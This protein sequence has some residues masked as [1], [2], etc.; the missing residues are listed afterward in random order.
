MKKTLILSA[1]TLAAFC[2]LSCQKENNE[3]VPEVNAEIETNKE[4]EHNPYFVPTKT[5]TFV[6]TV[7]D[8]VNADTKTSL[9]GTHIKWAANEGIYLFDGYAPRAFT[10]DNADVASTVNFE[11]SAAGTG[12]YWAVY[13]AGKISTVESKKVI[14]ATIPTIQAATANSF[15]AKANV[16]VAYTA[17]DPTGDGVLLFKNVGA[18]LKLKLNADNDN[19]SKI[20]IDA[21]GG[22][23]MT[24]AVDVTFESDGSF[25]SAIVNAKSESFV[26]LDNDG[27]ALD[28]SKTY[29]AAINKGTYTGGFRITLYN[30]DGT[31]FRAVKNTTTAV[32]DRNDLMDLGTLPKIGNSDWKAPVVDELTATLTGRTS[33]GDWSGKTS[34]SDAVYAGNS[35]KGD[36]AH[37]YALQIRSS[38]NS[39]IVTTASG[40]KAKRIVVDWQSGTA[41]NR[42][43]DV[44]GKNSAYTASSNLYSAES[45]TLGTKIGSIVYGTSTSLDIK[46]DYEY[47]GLRSNDGAMWF[48]NIKIYWGD[49]APEDPS[50]PVQTT[51]ITD[52][53]SSSVPLTS[54]S[55]TFTVSSNGPWTIASNQ[56]YATVTVSDSDVATVT[57]ENLASGSRSATITVTPAEGSQ[58]SVTITQQATSTYHYEALTAAPSDWTAFTYIIVANGKVLNGSVDGDWGL[59]NSPTIES[60]GTIKQ[61]SA[62]EACEVTVAGDNTNGYTLY[63][64]NLSTAAYVQPQTSKTFATTTST[65]GKV[66]LAI[67]SISNHSSTGWKL[68][69]NNDKFRWYNS[70]TGTAAVLY[71]KVLDSAE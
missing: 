23:K 69:L 65:P 6:G 7:D 5:V 49:V 51:S 38:S 26:I 45:S 14:R 13:P 70:N 10:S 15:A 61:T 29:F 21:I 59:V 60:D 1:A 39:G 55:A 47:I 58:Q 43:L 37:D 20:R 53:S 12:P 30:S 57:F 44:Y 54:G 33:Y 11:G 25:N 24:G 64:G 28:P 18:V 42:T 52:L 63:L 34:V 67:G 31:S 41:T 46:D 35:T 62:L 48:N 56:S 36:A 4:V 3:L 8:E 66:D 19:V 50:I 32:L 16:A 71:K 68:R 17:S 40:G 2:V 22:G 27:S 9:D